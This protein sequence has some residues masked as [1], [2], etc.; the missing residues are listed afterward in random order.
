MWSVGTLGYSIANLKASLTNVTAHTSALSF[1]L[2]KECA[3][4]LALNLLA[5]AF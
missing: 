5:G 1:R 2:V 3:I 4:S